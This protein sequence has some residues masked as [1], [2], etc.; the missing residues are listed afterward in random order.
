[1]KRSLAPLGCMLAL[2]AAC[3]AAP[4]PISEQW[5]KQDA[6]PE[7]VKRDAYWCSEVRVTARPN[8]SESTGFSERRVTQAVND[9]CM[10]K[11]GYTKVAGKRN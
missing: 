5:T 9:E 8:V 2:L 10:Q 7:D 4:P 1:M 6:T 3:T 11:R